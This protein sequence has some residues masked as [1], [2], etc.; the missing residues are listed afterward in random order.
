MSCRSHDSGNTSVSSNLDIDTTTPP[1]E[2]FKKETKATQKHL[3]G[4]E[5]Y[6]GVNYTGEK[7]VIDSEGNFPVDDYINIKSMKIYPSCR[8]SFDFGSECNSAENGTFKYFESDMPD[9]YATCGCDTNFSKIKEIFLRFN[10]CKKDDKVTIWEK[11]YFLGKSCYLP[12]TQRGEVKLYQLDSMNF[13]S[14]GCSIQIPP[15]CLVKVYKDKWFKDLIEEFSTSNNKGV[16][17]SYILD[18][19]FGFQRIKSISIYT[20]NPPVIDFGS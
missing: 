18:N 13:E 15:G 2:Y 10:L 6:T 7:F 1:L 14:G 4:V 12:L 19:K 11:P 17:K 20:I 8:V 3:T 9:I 5:F 16:E